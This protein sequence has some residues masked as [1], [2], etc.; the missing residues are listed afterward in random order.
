MLQR[1]GNLKRGQRLEDLLKVGS[2][3]VENLERLMEVALVGNKR[4]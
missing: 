4:K 3:N 2:T 1:V